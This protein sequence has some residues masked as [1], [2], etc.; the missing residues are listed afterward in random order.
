MLAI[1][2]ALA[3]LT[4]AWSAAALPGVQGAVPQTPS[5]AAACSTAEK[6]RRQQA[7][8]R[9]K[10]TMAKQRA[11]YFKKHRSA[12][13]RAAFVKKQKA[14]LRALQRAVAACARRSAPAPEPEVTR[15]DL[16]VALMPSA[17]RAPVGTQVAYTVTVRNAGP[18]AAQAVEARLLL[19]PALSV[20]SVAATQGRCSG[21]A[22]TSVCE[23]GAVGRGASATMTVVAT[24]PVRRTVTATATIGPLDTDPNP[25]DNAM[26]VSTSFVASGPPPPGIPPP[27]IPPPGL[28]PSG[29]PDLVAR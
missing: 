22:T 25:A 1:A 21:G 12:K 19:N 15:A 18:D 24:S 20:T 11:A 2:L 17:D 8:A 7:L 27:G 3:G 26:S 28:P 16:A 6:R 14:K 9:F 13:R 29:S 23:L 10:R 4:G 5:G